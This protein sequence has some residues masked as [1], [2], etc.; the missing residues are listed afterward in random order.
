MV[1]IGA[2]EG[3]SFRFTG[4]VIG[5]SIPAHR[6]LHWTLQ[7]YGPEAQSKLAEALFHALFEEE[8]DISQVDVLVDVMAG[9][10]KEVRGEEGEVRAFLEGNQGEEEVRRADRDIRESG[11]KGVPRFEIGGDS[12][13]GEREVLDGA[14]DTGEFFETILKIK[15][16]KAQ[17]NE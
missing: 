15:E 2:A 14:V 6:L 8:R 11:V 13:D 5:S 1:S 16:G 17:P 3:I 4:G 12:I 7:H 9:S 10:V